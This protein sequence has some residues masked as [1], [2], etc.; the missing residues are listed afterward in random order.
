[1]IE[2]AIV[3]VSHNRRWLANSVTRRR[4]VS[5]PEGC[6]FI[7]G[8]LRVDRSGVARRARPSLPVARRLLG[9]GANPAPPTACFVSGAAKYRPTPLLERS[10][11]PL[12]DV[13]LRPVR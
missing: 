3:G 9:A 7:G 13:D 6:E 1:M 5:D 11:Q 10:L 8:R 2:P 12:A 4:S